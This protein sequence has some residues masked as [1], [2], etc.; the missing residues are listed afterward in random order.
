MFF[1]VAR[2]S[3]RPELREGIGALSSDVWPEYN[4]HGDVIGSRWD[5]LYEDV[6]EFQFL[7]YD[8][9]VRRSSPRDTRSRA[10]GT[11]RPK[12]LATGSTR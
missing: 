2:H 5:R 9:E 11:E 3:E 10:L 1:V 4:L 7:L 8:A 6:P 12:V